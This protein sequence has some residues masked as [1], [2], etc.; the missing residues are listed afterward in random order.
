MV[1]TADI[2]G[3][4]YQ[5]V[6]NLIFKEHEGSFEVGYIAGKLSKTG[7]V[8]FMGGMDVPIIVKFQTGWEEGARYANPDKQRSLKL[9][10]LLDQLHTDQNQKHL[11]L[12]KHLD[13]KR[14]YLYK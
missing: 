3:E 7:K 6:Q 10:S 1:V 13:L 14:N 8:A 2:L 4:I 9:V 12:L 5:N 11:L